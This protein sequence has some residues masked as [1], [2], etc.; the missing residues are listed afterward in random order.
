MCVITGRWTSSEIKET[1]GV[2]VEKKSE[3]K[4]GVDRVDRREGIDRTRP[5]NRYPYMSLHAVIVLGHL[6]WLVIHRGTMRSTNWRYKSQE[7]YVE[8]YKARHQ[9]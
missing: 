2:Y 3:K 9:R 8:M 7:K 5:N 6:I 4:R 1:L